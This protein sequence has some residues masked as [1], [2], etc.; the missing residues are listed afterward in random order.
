MNFFKKLFN[1]DQITLQDVFNSL[2][3]F[4]N[5]MKS[6]HTFSEKAFKYFGNNWKF[7]LEMY[8]SSL[9]T[10]EKNKYYA[11]FKN[12]MEYEKALS[13]W[14]SA[15]QIIK[16]VKHVSAELLKA[17][18]EYKTYLTK[19]GIEGERL[20]EKLNSMF[21]IS[22]NKKQ[23][24]VSEQ[25][26]EISSSDVEHDAS[27]VAEIIESDDKVEDEVLDTEIET[28]SEDESDIDEENTP[29]DIV[30]EDE[31]IEEKVE[32][33]PVEEEKEEIV[34]TN[35][36]ENNDETVEEDNDEVEEDDSEIHLSKEK[37]EYRA[38]LKE[39][40][41]QKV[42]DIELRKKSL[43]EELE[44]NKKS[45][46]VEKN[47]KEEKSN[48]SKTAQKS[49][50]N[51]SIKSKKQSINKVNIDWILNNFK[52]IQEFLSES[53]E[54]MSAI[55]LYKNAESIEEYKNYGFIIDVIDYLIEKGE[56]I[57]STKSDS[58][59]E[60]IFP[61]GKEELRK[62]IEFYKNEKNNEVLL[63]DETLK[64]QG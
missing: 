52:K 1:K 11:K 29:S 63:P 18:P 25:S 32:E 33:I 24:E 31:V 35:I 48:P 54:V 64:N 61:G 59:I 42:R 50:K 51:K 3:A 56:E 44:E 5:D 23:E 38:Q 30:S 21:D 9:P 49:P 58:E 55:S 40:I 57:L 37:Q 12:V 22:V 20:F 46:E 19:F 47:I 27:D 53:R 8:I 62:T 17:M 43:K 7:N 14:T 28:S 16:G 13:I 26:K 36:S 39:R 4:D 34:E 60:N 15:L 45:V 6:L 10:D 41:L 2:D